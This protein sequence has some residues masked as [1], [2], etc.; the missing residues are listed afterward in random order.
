MQRCCQ[1]SEASAWVLP[2]GKGNL[3][4]AIKHQNREQMADVGDNKGDN[5][6]KRRRVLESK[7]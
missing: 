5:D 7:R 3:R 4:K 2:L 1:E 6:L